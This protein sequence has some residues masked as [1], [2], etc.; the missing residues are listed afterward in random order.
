MGYTNVFLY[1]GTDF[2]EDAG[3]RL[4][5]VKPEKMR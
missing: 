1:P 5:I 4:V 3:K 2:W